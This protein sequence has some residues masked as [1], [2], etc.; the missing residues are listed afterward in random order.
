MVPRDSLECPNCD[1]AERWYHRKHRFIRSA[2]VAHGV[3][4]EAAFVVY[5]VLST[6]ATVAENDKNFLRWCRGESVRHFGS[7]VRRVK[8]A[9]AGDYAAALA[10]KRG[11]KIVSFHENLRFPWRQGGAVTIDRHAADLITGDRKLS[12]N[13]LARKGGYA[14]AAAIYRETAPEGWRPHEWQA[15]TWVHHVLCNERKVA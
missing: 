1:G 7:V 6:N 9:T 2:A 3:D 10:Y 15:R 12:K 11:R 8:T 5:A 14:E 13:W 4:V